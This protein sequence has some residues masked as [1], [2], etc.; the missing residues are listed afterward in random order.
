M[1]NQIRDKRL[2]VRRPFLFVVLFTVLLLATRAGATAFAQ[3][4]DRGFTSHLSFG[5]SSNNSGQIYRLNPSIG[6]KINKHFKVGAGIPVYFVR[7]S[8]TSLTAGFD[9]KSGIGNAYVDLQMAVNGPATYFSSTLR[10]A[11]PTG[12]K[13]NGFSTGR[14]TIDWTN[15]LEGTAGRVTPFGSVGFANTI[16]DTHFFSRPFS[17]LGL[18]SNF[19]GGANFEISRPVSVGASGYAVVPYGQQKVFS[20]LLRQ[21]SSGSA[22]G[23]TNRGRGRVF[24]NESVTIGDAEIDRDHGVSVWLDLSP[25]PYANFEVGYSRSVRYAFNTIFFSI[26]FNLRDLARRA[27]HP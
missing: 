11:A 5:G 21:R 1:R 4:S 15:Y 8:T 22:P 23:T 2:Q 20:K 27:K 6:Y 24:E 10:T 13:D 9:S 19:E 7:A 14:L 18:V 25:S 17:S 12:D 16:S 3:D 26:R